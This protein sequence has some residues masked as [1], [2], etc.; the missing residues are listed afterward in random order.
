[1]P[2]YNCTVCGNR[3]TYPAGDERLHK[4]MHYECALCYTVISTRRFVKSSNTAIFGPAGPG[5]GDYIFKRFLMDMFSTDNPGMTAIDMIDPCTGAKYNDAIVF[6][7]DNAGI[8]NTPPPGAYQYKLTNEVLS[9]A[10]QGYCPGLW[11]DKEPVDIPFR[12][13]I[14]LNMRN[15]ERCSDKNVT[16]Y[17]ADQ[18][19]GFAVN[20]VNF[21]YIDGAVII[22]ND[23]KAEVMR[24]PDCILDLRGQ[25]SL[26]Q[27]AAV[28][29]DAVV[30]VGKDSGI[31]HLAAAAGGRVVGWG[32]RLRQ[33]FPIAPPGC[34]VA[35]LGTECFGRLLFHDILNMIDRKEREVA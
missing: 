9:Y 18:L 23:E 1:M 31:L 28:C 6:W 20:A 4:D 8:K 13:Y 2:H 16:P 7:A 12:H 33:W 25:L 35:H 27:L 17:E 10:R 34:V 3:V 26:G 5:I 14:V 15:I 24:L 29:G 11:F 19:V 22:G 21:R 30:T 32:Y